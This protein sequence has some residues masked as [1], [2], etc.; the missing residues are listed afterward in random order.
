M[1]GIN[2]KLFDSKNKKYVLHK[3]SI[4]FQKKGT[5]VESG[6]AVLKSDFGNGDN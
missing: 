1:Y 4:N 3:I 5:L 6:R 2:S